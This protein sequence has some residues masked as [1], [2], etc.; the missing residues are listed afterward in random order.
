MEFIERLRD[1]PRAGRHRHEICIAV[2]SRHDME[3]EM[4]GNPRPGGPL[5]VHPEVKAV[6][7][8][9]SPQPMQEPSAQLKHSGP[10]RGGERLEASHMPIRR[11]QEMAVV[12]RVAVQQGKHPFASSHHVPLAM[13]L[14]PFGRAED[15]ARPP[16]LRDEL[17]APG[18][19]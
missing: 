9:E 2:P 11:D 17:A 19:P 16:A 13:R 8:Q 5:E 12:V 18:R 14:R 7:T 6:R 4:T 1:D 15:A 3:V 10:L